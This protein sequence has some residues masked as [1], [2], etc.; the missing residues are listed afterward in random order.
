MYISLFTI[1]LRHPPFLA[2]FVCPLQPGVQDGG[3]GGGGMCVSIG[4]V[5]GGGGGSGRYATSMI[6]R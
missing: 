2:Y 3:G 6:L 1:F 4:G 5:K